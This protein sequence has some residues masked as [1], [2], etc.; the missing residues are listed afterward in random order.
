MKE[1]VIRPAQPTLAIRNRRATLETADGVLVTFRVVR[2]EA[3]DGAHAER[4]LPEDGR[5]TLVSFRTASPAARVLLRDRG[6]SY[7]A[8][9]GEWFL[10]AP[11]VYVE[12]PSARAALP[13]STQAR[14]AFATRASRVARW[15]LLHP[16]ARPS[17]G[18]LA[19]AVA[20]SEPTVSRTTKALGEAGLIELLEDE[21]DSRIRR[22][23]TKDTG[24]MLESLERS[25]W[26]AR[27]RRQTWDIGASDVSAAL[28]HWRDSADKLA[29]PY[30]IGGPTGASIRDRVIE[31]ADVLVWIR[32]EDLSLWREDLL[33]ETVRPSRGTVTVQ[34]AAD[35]FIF[36]LA[37]DSDGLVIADPVQLYL[38]CRRAGERA[39]EAAAAIREAMGW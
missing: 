32:A 35:P 14:S 8:D 38:D 12:R 21:S 6:I 25:R 5:P 3:L 20:L 2:V 29:L 13:P 22:V 15:L 10:F 39:L 24:A 34:I 16:D 17:L 33:A 36:E 7:A 28:R 18:E 31:P 4:L 9:D 30:A 23:R 11:P 1:S 37:N 19:H 27:A 26:L